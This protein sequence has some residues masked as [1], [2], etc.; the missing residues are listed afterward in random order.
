MGEFNL[1]AVSEWVWARV[2]GEATTMVGA[3]PS[4]AV[5]RSGLRPATEFNATEALEKSAPRV[6]TKG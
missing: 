6:K 2:E 1:A 5:T 4:V 3:T